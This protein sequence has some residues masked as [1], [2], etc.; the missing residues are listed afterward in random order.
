MGKIDQLGR[1]ERN[2]GRGLQ[3]ARR[4]KLFGGACEKGRCKRGPYL[5]LSSYF[6]VSSLFSPSQLTQ[7][8]Q[9]ALAL[10]LLAACSKHLDF[11]EDA[12]SPPSNETICETSFPKLFTSLLPSHEKQ[13]IGVE[14]KAVLEIATNFIRLAETNRR[15]TQFLTLAIDCWITLLTHRRVSN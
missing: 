14:E 10:R 6:R 1:Q 12:F 4:S 5:H 7:S 8:V 9:R 13:K 15:R 2:C 3:Q 11:L